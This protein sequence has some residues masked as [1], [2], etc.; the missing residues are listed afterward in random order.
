MG[1]DHNDPS[2]GGRARGHSA[3]GELKGIKTF[4]GLTLHRFLPTVIPGCAA[5]PACT[6]VTCLLVPGDKSPFA[7]AARSGAMCPWQ[8]VAAAVCWGVTSVPARGGPSQGFCALGG[9]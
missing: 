2:S 6:S 1:G 5:L 3:A 9:C 7:S 4:A 8:L